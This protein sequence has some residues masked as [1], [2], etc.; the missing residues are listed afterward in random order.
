MLRLAV[1]VVGTRQVVRLV[2]AVLQVWRIA[3]ATETMQRMR[4]LVVVVRKQVLVATAL[5]AKY[6]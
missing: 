6:S 4:A 5:L 2:L 3:V 1:V